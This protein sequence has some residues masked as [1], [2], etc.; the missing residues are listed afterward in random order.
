MTN[1]DADVGVVGAGLAG[2]YAVH[3][4]T[5]QGLS[6]VGLE[7]AGWVGGVWY[8]NRYP[9]ARVDLDSID[10]CYYFSPE[11]WQKWRW[12]ERY[13]SQP[14]LLEYL[15]FVADHHDVKRHFHFN[16]RVTGAQWDSSEARYLVS[17]DAGIQVRCRFLVMTTGQL[18]EPRVASFP[19][20]DRFQGQVVRTSRWPE[21]EVPLDDRRIG[22][23]G[24]GSTA[25]QAIPILAEHAEHLYVFQRSARYAVPARN[26]AISAHSQQQIADRVR[27]E[28]EELFTKY[29]GGLRSVRPQRTAAD[30]SPDEQVRMMERQWELGGQRMIGI[31]ADQGINRDANDIVA[32]F[33][34]N[35]IRAMVQDPELAERLCPTYPIG[36]RRLALDTG[37]YDTFNRPNVSLIDIKSDPIVEITETGIRT[38]AAHYELDLIVLAIGFQAFTGAL[39]AANIRNEQGAMPSDGW[40]LGPRTLLGLMTTGFPNLFT[41]TA[42]G[43]PSVLANLFI[44]NEFEIDWI[45]DCIAHLDAHGLATIEPTVEAQDDWTEQVAEVS[46]RLLRRQENDYMVHVNADGSRIF[47]P[48]VGGF[49]KYVA[50]A[51]GIAA[52]G[53]GGFVLRDG[54]GRPGASD[55]TIGA[56]GDQHPERAVI[57]AE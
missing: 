7:A 29:A 37:Y 3:R 57:L 49:D 10:Y 38:G 1:F 54:A 18:S 50:T 28:R 13:A 31:F 36:T 42:P 21:Q 6:V 45:G 55:P 5:N 12:T 56:P 47:M 2:I 51:R 43:T 27:E 8:H 16:S 11:I 17:T 25:V 53:Y 14:E 15:N 9:G 48:Y 52:R 33:V 35:K 30:C 32:E 41:P 46:S 4:F 44:Q 34:R 24:T 26:R 40:K 19:G 22:I 39:D 20:L 23:I